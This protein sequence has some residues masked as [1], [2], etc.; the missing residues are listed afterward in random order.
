MSAMTISR[1]EVWQVNLDPTIGDEMRKVRPAVVV[2]RDALGALA[3]RVLVPITAWQDRFQG[4]DWLVRLDPDSENGLEKSSAADTLQVRS[5][6]TQR[7]VRRLGRLAPTDLKRIEA[8]LRLV[9]E[10]P[11]PEHVAPATE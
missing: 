8:G 10:L 11:S 3:L 7:L 6:A 1:G 4:S 5:L 9:L 2:S